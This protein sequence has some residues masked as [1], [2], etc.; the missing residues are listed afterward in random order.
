MSNLSC[1]LCD[2]L[3]DDSNT[4]RLSCNPDKHYFCYDC[5]EKWFITINYNKDAK[6]IYKKR[7]CPICR[8]TTDLIPLLDGKEYIKNIHKSPS[9]KIC[10][11]I[12]KDGENTCCNTGKEMYGGF[13]GIHKKSALNKQQENV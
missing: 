9:K 7:E 8:D 13:C 2:V 12:L 11:H 5:I 1:P 6:T 10:G 4:I 3:L